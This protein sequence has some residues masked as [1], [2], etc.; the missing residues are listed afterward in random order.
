[1]VYNE[2]DKRIL[3]IFI[4]NPQLGKVKTRIARTTGDKKALSIYQKLLNFT[5]AITLEVE[6]ERWLFYSDFIDNQDFWHSDDFEK[7]MQSDGD[8]GIRME[9]AFQSAFAT[10]ASKVLIIGSDCPE[11]TPEIINTA[12][13]QLNIH[14]FVLGPTL[15]GGYYLLGMKSM[16][17]EVFKEIEW[18]TPSV[19][20]KTCEIIENLGK[21][22]AFL[23]KLND[24]DTEEDWL[25]YKSVTTLNDR[26]KHKNT[27]TPKHKLQ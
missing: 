27:K 9:S 16:Q 10:Q 8:L 20:A 19:F 2:L 25:A 15:D 26:P 7:K 5:K 17:P 11:L 14:D 24:I 12:F 13:S 23:P 18:S 4:K 22:I 3:L 6:S 1:M 21:S